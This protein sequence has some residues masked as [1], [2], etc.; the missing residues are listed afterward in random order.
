MTTKNK[1]KTTNTPITLHNKID[2]I[3]KM[4]VF[5][6]D[7]IVDGKITNNKITDKLDEIVDK[8]DNFKDLL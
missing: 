8:I 5:L 3:K 6:Y 1:N 7:D 2:R 4:I